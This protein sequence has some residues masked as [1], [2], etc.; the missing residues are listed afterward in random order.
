MALDIEEINQMCSELV[1]KMS[2]HINRLFKIMEKRQNLCQL[3]ELFVQKFGNFCEFNE[4]EIN[5]EKSLH[6][7]SCK[8]VSEA[9]L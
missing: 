4:K 1:F 2:D 5:V 9:K 8:I 7:N 6:I 3:N